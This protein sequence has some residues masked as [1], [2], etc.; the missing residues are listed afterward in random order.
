ML[1][2]KPAITYLKMQDLHLQI[3]AKS[4]ENFNQYLKDI[5][6]DGIIETIKHYKILSNKLDENNKL[7]L[8][9]LISMAE[10]ILTNRKQ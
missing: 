3:I 5:S 8:E 1:I 4:Q 2:L 7:L 10:Q 6:N 9:D